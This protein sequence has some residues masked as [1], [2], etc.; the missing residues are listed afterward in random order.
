MIYLIRHGESVLNVAHRITCKDRV[1]ELTEKG[2]DQARRAGQWLKD[3]EIEAIYTSPFERAQETAGLIGE[4]IGLTPEI[5]DDLHELDC[6]ELEGRDDKAAW[7]IVAAAMTQWKAGEWE[8][9][10]TESGESLREARDRLQAALLRA[11]RHDG[12]VALVTHGGVMSRVLPYLLNTEEGIA[13]N[14]HMA[15]TGIVTVEP[16]DDGRYICGGWNL[17]EHLAV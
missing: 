11:C 3:K 16:C 2:R 14:D 4:V 13:I 12:N 9:R 10:F 15:N 1:G 6:G 5:D 7:D 8:A 17:V